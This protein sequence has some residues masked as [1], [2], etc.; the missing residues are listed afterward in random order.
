MPSPLPRLTQRSQKSILIIGLVAV[1]LL[2][3]VGLVIS[4]HRAKT[5]VS[6]INYTQL[7]ALGTAGAATGLSV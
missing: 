1:S 7:H 4:L 2:L 6:T 5:T 3:I